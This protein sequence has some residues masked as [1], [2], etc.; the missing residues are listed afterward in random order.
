MSLSRSSSVTKSDS[1]PLTSN[2][3]ST[4][5]ERKGSVAASVD[6]PGESSEGDKIGANNGQKHEIDRTAVEAVENHNHQEVKSQRVP[7]P[8]PR[9]PTPPK[10][11]LEAL[12]QVRK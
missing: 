10:V 12:R 8:P 4:S 6:D 11:D 3:S 5:Q 2:S 7:T 1:T 9:P